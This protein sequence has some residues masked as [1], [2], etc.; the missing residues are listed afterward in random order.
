MVN[1]SRGFAVAAAAAWLSVASAADGLMAVASPRGVPETMD[2][3]EQ[4]VE[5][6][7]LKVFARIDHAAGAASIDASLRPTQLLIFGNPRGGTP[8]MACAQTVGIDL[9]L[10]ALVWEDASGRVWIG[11]NDPAFIA[12]R[13]EVGACPAVDDLRRALEGLVAAA[14]EP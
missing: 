4:L 6:R 13:H 12:E 3:L 14:V 1:R 7:G 2:R 9:P 8:F 5:Q 10:K 11:Y